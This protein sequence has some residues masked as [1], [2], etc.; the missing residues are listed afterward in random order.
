ETVRSRYI[1][2]TAL[3]Q[4]LVDFLDYKILSL[5]QKVR[6][7]Q[8]KE[9]IK[10]QNPRAEVVSSAAAAAAAAVTARGLATGTAPAVAVPVTFIVQNGMI[11]EKIADNYNI[12]FEGVVKNIENPETRKAVE[13][14]GVTVL[15]FFVANVL[16]LSPSPN[17]NWGVENAA[18]TAA[19]L[20]V[21]QIA[22]SHA[23]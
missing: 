23:A 17:S 3:A 8:V 2:P 14:V 9:I 4:E 21:A 22:V 13:Q 19:G 18:G 6:P 1:E 7:D 20:G 12:G 11:P 5:A 16:G 15:S 10:R